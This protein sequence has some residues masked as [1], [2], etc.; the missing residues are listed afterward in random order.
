MKMNLKIRNSMDFKVSLGGFGGNKG[1]GSNEAKSAIGIETL[2]GA[3][4][5]G[6]TGG[7]YSLR[8]WNCWQETN[9]D[10]K[11][12]ATVTAEPINS[13]LLVVAAMCRDEVSIDG[14]GWTKIVESVAAEGFTQKIV[15]WAKPVSKGTYTVTVNQASSA[16]LSLKAMAIYKCSSLSLIDNT[17]ISAFPHTPTASSG[18]RRLYMLSGFYATGSNNTINIANANGL[19]LGSAEELRFSIFYDYQPE[20]NAVPVFGTGTN[21]YNDTDANTAQILTFDIEEE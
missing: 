6:D 12:T 19:V 10:V 20:L 18:K 9:D 13:C 8:L 2:A 14:D 1:G 11:T 17:L 16:R 7:A 3:H 15:V 5:L 4:V 21:S